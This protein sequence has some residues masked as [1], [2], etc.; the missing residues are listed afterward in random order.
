MYEQEFKMLNIAQVK[1]KSSVWHRCPGN[2]INN[3]GWWPWVRP[4]LLNDAGE[5]LSTVGQAQC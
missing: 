5:I 1:K 3:C 2:E 4:G